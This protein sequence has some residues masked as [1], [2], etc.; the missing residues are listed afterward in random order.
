MSLVEQEGDGA[1]AVDVVEDEG[2]EVET[3]A[4]DEA[5]ADPEAEAE[6]EETESQDDETVVSLG[7]KPEVEEEQESS[8]FREVRKRLREAERKAKAA[9]AELAQLKAP[10]KPK[11]GARP[12]PADSDYDDDKHTAALEAWL[13]QKAAVEAAETEERKAQSQQAD[14]WTQTVARYRERKSALKVPDFDDAEEAVAATLSV[15]QQSAIMAYADQPEALIYALGR[16]EKKL[17]ELAGIKDILKFT[18]TVA[19]LEAKELTVT[20]A[21]KS[22]PK[23]A[24][25]VGGNANATAGSNTRER[26]LKESEKSNDVTNLVDEL[27]RKKAK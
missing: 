1:D 5:E 23:P 13:K 16:N 24:K 25:T 15:A 8:V 26:L 7:G 21:K 22:P 14:E 2:H 20:T 11:L 12:T 19:R 3:E 17:T 6:A 4:E 18:A 27:R 10:A 9:E